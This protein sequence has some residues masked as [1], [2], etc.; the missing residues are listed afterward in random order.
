MLLALI[1]KLI[2]TEVGAQSYM[3]TQGTEIAGHV[4]NLYGFLVVVSTISCAILIG[5][6][7][8]FALKYKRKTANDKTAYITH[9]TRLEVLWSVLPL[10]IFLFV[11]AWG[12]IIYHDMRTM[13]KNALEIHVTGKQWAWTSEYKNGVRSNEVVVPV[14]QDVKIIL[15][16]E[17][18]IHS[19]YVPSF[20]IKQD[21]VPGRYTA[22]WFHADK[23][24]EFHVFCTEFCGTAHS[25]MI[26]KLRVLSREDYEKWLTEEA[27]VSTLPVAQRGAKLFQTRACASC[28]NV[29]NPAVKIGPSLQNAFGMAN[30]E[31]A[32]GSKV[33][34]DENYL[35][36]SIL[37]A[38]AKIVKGFKGSDGRSQM[39]AFQGQLSEAEVVALIEYIKTLK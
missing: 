28:H 5:G 11:F 10:I 34:I 4:D 26:T 25:A 27:D 22:L 38:Q 3:P 20:R 16:S 36:E 19:F 30:H 21:A 12:W 15:S 23:L 24:G 7:I 29:D 32:D 33:D 8:Y 18:V 2:F 39:P 1:Q 37:N 17:D 13:P 9:D 6:M 31:M 14:N 35:R